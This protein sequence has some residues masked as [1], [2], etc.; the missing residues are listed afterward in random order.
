MFEYSFGF[1]LTNF[2]K[3]N[4]KKIQLI[5][6]QHGIFSDNIM[7]LDLIKNNKKLLATEN[8]SIKQNMCWRLQKSN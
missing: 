3:N 8:C 1:F 2:F 5:G 6:Y 4:F 7:W